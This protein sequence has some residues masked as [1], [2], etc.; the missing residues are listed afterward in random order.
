MKLPE[1]IID[2][3]SQCADGESDAKMQTT[4]EMIIIWDECKH[5][6]ASELAKEN[7]SEPDLAKTKTWYVES[8][9]ASVANI[10][11]S[12]GYNRMRVGENV[13][14]RGYDREHETISFAVWL[15]LLRNLK[16]VDG[17]IPRED[18]D[19]RLDWYYSEFDEWGKPP[20]VRDIENHVK[21]NG[22]TPEDMI[23]WKRIVNNAN[24]MAKINKYSDARIMMLVIEIIELQKIIK[25]EHDSKNTERTTAST[26]P[27]FDE[28]R[29]SED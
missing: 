21:K 5:A 18:I 3:I 19:K 22:D 27:Q 7:K 11:P 17:L 2:R 6:L 23:Y 9:C 28:V 8:V 4:R 14:L 16:K 25:G 29:T 15:Y 13:V 24:Q 10:A 12:S 1:S 26:V 20:S